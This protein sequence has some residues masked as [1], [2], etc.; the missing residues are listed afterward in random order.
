MEA[1]TNPI[2]VKSNTLP[3]G[4][5]PLD[6]MLTLNANFISGAEAACNLGPR[7]MSDNDKHI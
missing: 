7:N 5:M 2:F 6:A 1:G 4:K 3:D